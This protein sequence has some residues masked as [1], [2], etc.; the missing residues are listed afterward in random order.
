MIDQK[1]ASVQVDLDALMERVRGTIARRRDKEPAAAPAPISLD[2]IIRR[3]TELNDVVVRAIA[4]F[5]AQIAEL[6]QAASATAAPVAQPG[7]AAP[8]VD[9][10]EL[11]QTMD[12]LRKVERSLAALAATTDKIARAAKSRAAADRQRSARI[13]GIDTRLNDAAAKAEAALN[14]FGV[15]EEKAVARLDEMRMRVLRAERAAVRDRVEAPAA[16]RE[17][18]PASVLPSMPPFDYFMF[19]HRF[20]GTSDDIK[21]RQSK[22]LELFE[23]R[24]H[25]LDLG[26]GRGEFLQIALRHG[27]GVTGV[28]ASEDM[29]AFCRDL[30]LPAT[31]ADLFEHLAGLPECSLDGIFCSQVLEHLEPRDLMRFVHLAATRLRPGAPIVI[32]TVNP[33]CPLALGNF[34]LDPT[35]VRPVPPL[36]LRFV[37]E[38]SLFSVQTLRF[39]GPVPGHA[40]VDHV[41]GLEPMPAGID[42]YQDYAALAVRT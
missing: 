25:V 16:A 41:E 37:L 10:K 34:F 1:D 2:G 24:Q 19:E 21:R 28:D 11:K 36:L 17:D 30:G 15:V 42:A 14:H 3:Q 13:A 7:P 6:K 38:Q 12:A 18:V 23:G 27:I 4:Q 26:C 32:E 35:H 31:R 22:Y 40:G 9:A 8:P 5:A 33:H 39:T 20:R 29:V